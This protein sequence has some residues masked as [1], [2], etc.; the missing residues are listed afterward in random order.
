MLFPAMLLSLATLAAEQPGAHAAALEERLGAVRWGGQEQAEAPPP[1]PPPTEG[2]EATVY[3]YWPYWGDDLDTVAWDQLS[4]IAIFGVVLE[5][6]GSLSGAGNWTDVAAQAVELGRRYEVKV[7]LC[8]IGFEDEVHADVFPSESRRRRA[9]QELV[10]LVDT[11]G[12]DGVNVDIEGLDNDLKDDFTTF[13]QELRVEVDELFLATPAVDWSSA[14]DYDELAAASDGL[15]IMAYGYH[16]SSSDPGP[17]SPLSGGSPWSDR[18]IDWSVED[19]RDNGTPDDK[20][21][22]G[23]PL[24]GRNWPSTDNSV[25]GDATGEGSSV[26]W[27]SAIAQAE[28]SG[29]HWDAVTSTPYTFPD[30]THQLWYDDH[31]SLE[32]KIGW[33]VDEGLQGVGFWALTYE[34]GDA[35]LWSMVHR[36]TAPDPGPQD[37]DTPDDSAPSQDTEPPDDTDDPSDAPGIRGV[38]GVG[39]GCTG[40]RTGPG[41]VLVLLASLGL[42]RRRRR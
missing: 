13:I 25:P 32:H 38:D 23:L 11:Y 5:S 14:Y 12:A 36:L 42:V 9:I 3:G 22:V 33:S 37:S 40:T 27:V 31:E 7:H 15:F 19:Y 34:D 8:L 6:D 4:H 30:S 16:Y 24:Y 10:E 41:G 28:Q 21:I 39:C 18:A 26:T 17:N 35:D 29:R 2:P 20:I 1:P